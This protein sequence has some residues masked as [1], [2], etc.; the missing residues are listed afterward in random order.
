[1]AWATAGVQTN[2]AT[3]AILA[4]SGALATGVTEATVILGASVACICTIEQRNAANS[5]NVNTQVIAVAANAVEQITLPGVNLA[6][7]ERIRLRLNVGVT[8][9]VQASV[10][11]F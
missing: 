3:D 6:A 9:S 11:T 1:M 2:P 5:A 7:S 8:G 4:D 10:F